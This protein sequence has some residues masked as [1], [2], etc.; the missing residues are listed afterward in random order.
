V[1][2]ALLASIA[3][4][5]LVVSFLAADH[6]PIPNYFMLPTRAWELLI[7]AVVAVTP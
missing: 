7:G 5:S 1:R 6:W 4:A 3:L 2:G